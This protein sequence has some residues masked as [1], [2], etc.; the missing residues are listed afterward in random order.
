MRLKER[1][2][3]VRPFWILFA[4]WLVVIAYAYPGYLNWD[5]GDQLYQLRHHRVTD[6]HPPMMAGYWWLIEHLF[7][8]P[9]GMLVLQT[10]L[11]QWGLYEAFSKRF[12]P[13]MSAVLASLLVLFPPILTPM[14]VVWKDAQMAGFLLA[15][16][17]LCLRP[18]WWARGIGLVLL[19][20]ATGVRDNAAAALPPLCLLFVASWH[21]VQRRIAI[22]VVAFGVFVAVCG[23]AAVSNSLLTDKRAFAW[24]KTVAIHDLAGT[25]CHEDPMS[26]E[27][28]RDLLDGVH[29]LQPNALQARFCYAYDVRVWFGLTFFGEYR[30][31]FEQNPDKADRLARK[32]AWGR[33]VREHPH[34][35]LSHRFGVMKEVLGWGQSWI[36]EPV[37]QTFA[38]NDDH[39]R[40][41]HHDAS[42]SW[43][44]KR[45]GS[46]FRDKLGQTIFYRPWAYLFVGLLLFAYA[47]RRRDTY[48]CTI[49]G[50][51]FLYESGYFMF[52][53]APDFRYS[54]FMIVCVC[55]AALTIF[56]ERAA[57]RQSV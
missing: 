17:M 15:G 32:K 5:S 52:A 9:F 54:H 18:S 2:Q 20:L 49:L 43:F 41:L 6:W 55:F 36:W 56:V 31:M 10:S 51:G 14:A 44:Q 16:A 4:A 1:L 8:G 37:C 12:T 53:A 26:D 48:L 23:T 38:A 34:A 35:W 50:S 11:F 30:N 40:R 42:L 45:L 27:E 39:L 24:Y 22:C 57:K 33:A 29:I 13:R 25:I 19:V 21:V 47:V 7:H 46:F 28:I 3:A